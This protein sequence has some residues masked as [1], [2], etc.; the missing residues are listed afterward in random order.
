MRTDT[1]SDLKHLIEENVK[2]S[3]AILRST[4]KTRKHLRWIKIMSI[5]RIL[6]IVVPLV[7][8]ILYVPPF[9]SKLNDIFG[10]LYGGEQFNILQQF[11][12]LNTGGVDIDSLL[13]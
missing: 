3:K 1:T 8:A 2:L 9:L 11:K 13:K 10:N 4:E 6:L 5:V 7:I 12:N